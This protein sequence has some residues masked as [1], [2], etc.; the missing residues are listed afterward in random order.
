MVLD[1]FRSLAAKLSAEYA[2]SVS[3]AWTDKLSFAC[4][5]SNVVSS[6]IF[7]LSARIQGCCGEEP[8]GFSDATK[9]V[10]S[11]QLPSKHL[12]FIQ[13]LRRGSNATR[14]APADSSHRPVRP[15]D[16]MQSCWHASLMRAGRA[17]W[18]GNS[19]EPHRPG[20]SVGL[21][22]S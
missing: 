3:E 16:K 14:E 2:I 19:D 12:S 13:S 10:H 6:S 4:G 15:S 5:R 11:T 8:L 9:H 18:G 1:A 17:K 22:V 21:A 7:E 20:N